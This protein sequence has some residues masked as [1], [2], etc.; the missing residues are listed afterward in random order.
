MHMILEQKN[1]DE[2]PSKSKSETLNVSSAAK[3]DV[4]IACPIRACMLAM[5]F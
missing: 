3:D 5:K 4:P 1:F 2:L